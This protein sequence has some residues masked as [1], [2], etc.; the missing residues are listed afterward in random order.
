M[1]FKPLGKRVLIKREEES[2]TTA[3]GLIIPDSAKEKPFRGEVLAVGKKAKKI[4]INIGDTVVFGKFINS[5][6]VTIDDKEL[7]ILNSDDIYGII[8]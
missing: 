3:S 4:G 1:T 7:L 2:N 8:N 6:E 5:T